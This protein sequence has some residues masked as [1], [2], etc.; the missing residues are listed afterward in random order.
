MID[1]FD[2]VTT[3]TG[4][5]VVSAYQEL[6]DSDCKQ[7][8]LWGYCLRIENNSDEAITLLKKNLCFTDES[9]KTVYDSSVGF[10]GELPD[11]LPGEYFEYEETAQIN[12]LS[13]VLY[14]FCSAIT[15]K[16]K[17]IKIKLPILNF[18]TKQVLVAN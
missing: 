11:L 8:G 2:S 18:D 12:G 9:G 16:G 6:I 1:S 5:I 14:G 7:H 4:D 15:S 13:S 3:Q 10:N 17:E